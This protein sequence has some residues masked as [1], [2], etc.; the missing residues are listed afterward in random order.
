[1]T[2]SGRSYPVLRKVMHRRR[3]ADT[4]ED[5]AEVGRAIKQ[6]GVPRE[7]I[8]I[9]SKLWN[10]FH[11]PE[12]VESTLD[13]SLSRLGTDYLDLYLMHWYSISLA[14]RSIKHLHV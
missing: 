3:G 4:E 1:M 6:S 7:E 8:W 14:A 11:A 5:E 10:S 9:T 12:D 2:R 13:E